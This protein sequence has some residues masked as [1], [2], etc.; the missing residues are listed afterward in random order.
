MVGELGSLVFF[1]FLKRDSVWPLLCRKRVGWEIQV[2]RV[3]NSVSCF[4]RCKK[5]VFLHDIAKSIG[6][7]LPGCPFSP[8][9]V[10]VP[11]DAQAECFQVRGHF[12]SLLVSSPS[13]IPVA[14]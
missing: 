7:F 2:A 10:W 14:A 6:R 3:L 9:G 1:L 12:D 11:V 13:I 4:A 8:V 5:P